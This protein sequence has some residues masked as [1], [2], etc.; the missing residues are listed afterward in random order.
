[1]AAALTMAT[2]RLMKDL[3]EV[4]ES[5]LFN[6]VGEPEEG[7]LF[8]WHVNIRSSEGEELEEQEA[9]PLT[10]AVFHLILEFPSSF[11]AEG[12]TVHL[13]TPLPHPNVAL[14]PESRHCRHPPSVVSTQ[15]VNWLG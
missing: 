13:C 3:Q 9:N 7:N 6:V 2:R 11:P 15:R 10:G 4:K 5:P 12:P 1:M 8:V 14:Q